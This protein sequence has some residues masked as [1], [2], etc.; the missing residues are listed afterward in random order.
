[1][2]IVYRKLA[3]VRQP[4]VPICKAR[5]RVKQFPDAAINVRWIM[6]VPVSCG[7]LAIRRTPS[8]T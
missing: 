7:P 1:M 6:V 5:P 4:R 8:A 2:R 3:V